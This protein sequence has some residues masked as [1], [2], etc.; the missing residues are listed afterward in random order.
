MLRVIIG[1]ALGFVCGYLLGSERA[2]E[3]AYRQF[4]RAPEPV[5]QV[6]ER[7]SSAFNE[8]QMPDAVKQAAT[9]ASDALQT[10][11]GQ[12]TTR[13]NEAVQTANDHAAQMS[14]Q[15]PEVS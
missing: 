6:T 9:R 7:I 10:A 13:A 11:T 15:L 14:E 1:I 5:R 4:S 8:T 12:A 3:E 2:R